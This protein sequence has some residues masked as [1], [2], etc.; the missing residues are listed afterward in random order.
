LPEPASGDFSALICALADAQIDFVV[1]GG[2]AS[3]LHGA[4]YQTNDLDISY[5]RNSGNFEKLSAFLTKVHAHLRGA[6]RD[7]PFRPDPATLKA[8]LNFTFRT[9]AG[10]LDLLGELSGLGSHDKVRENS[11]V[12]SLFGRQV[13]VLNLDGLIRSK[14]AADRPKDRLAIPELEALA[15]LKEQRPG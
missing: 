3:I 11:I 14:R 5:A 9:D 2:I 8:G 7:L 13:H 1:V 6:P 12:V 4:A 15:A 10:D